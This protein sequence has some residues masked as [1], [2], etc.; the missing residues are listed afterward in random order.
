MPKFEQFPEGKWIDEGDAL[1]T[2]ATAFAVTSHS[3]VRRSFVDPVKGVERELV[4]LIGAP[5]FEALK[6]EHGCTDLADVSANLD[7]WFCPVCH[8]GGRISGA[9][10]F[11]VY[12]EV[13]GLVCAVK[14][15]HP[16]ETPPTWRDELSGLLVCDRH[17]AQYDERDDLGPYEWV[18]VS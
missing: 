4:V 12:D 15:G 5:V 1:P 18:R 3:A 11:D 10:A 14:V 13:N 2:S 9:W 16:A 7:A 6:V 17:R 8:A